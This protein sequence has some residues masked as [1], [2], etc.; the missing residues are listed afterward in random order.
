MKD[1]RKYVEIHPFYNGIAVVA[2][3]GEKGKRYGYINEYGK[4]IVSPRFS[5]A[6]DFTHDIAL[7]QQRHR[8]YFIDREGKKLND[9]S[10]L[11]VGDFVDRWTLAQ[12]CSYYNGISSY[13]WINRYGEWIISPLYEEANDFQEGFA[14]VK[15]EGKWGFIKRK[16][17]YL[18]SPKYDMAGNFK[19]GFAK[20]ELN[21]KVGYID[22]RG[23]WYDEK[24]N[25]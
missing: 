9:N 23:K 10:F 14:S 2:I 4:E 21:G 17:T 7:V 11:K 24:P 22:K 15:K 19:D 1:K 5:F 18:V 3:E 13:G 16:G 20:V 25:V 8:F 6:Q 12:D